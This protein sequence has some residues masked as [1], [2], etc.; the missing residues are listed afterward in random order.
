MIE[1]ILFVDDDANL[2]SSVE[3][4]YRRQFQLE[5]AEGAEAGLA[6]IAE[7][8]PFAVVISDRQM[9]GMDGVQ[10]LSQVRKT[11]PD[12]VRVMLTGNVDLEQAVKAVNEGNIFRFLI[13][14]AP[15]EVLVK[16]LQDAL[17]QYRLITAEK[18]LLNKTLSG[19]IKL[20]TDILSAIE[21]KSVGRT[22]RLRTLITEAAQKLSMADPWEIHLAAMLAPIG[23]VTLPPEITMK[24]RAGQPL[25]KKEEMMLNTVPE[26]AAR[27]LSN[28]PRLQGVSNIVRY[29]DKCYD[30]SGIPTDLVR[31]EAIPAGARLLKILNDMSKLQASNSLTP[32]QALKEMRR[33]EGW[34]DPQ[35]LNAVGTCFGGESVGGD[36][37]KTV[38]RKVT[39]LSVGMVLTSDIYTT[40][41]TLVLT[42]GHQFNDMTLERLQNFEQLVGIKMPIFVE[43]L[44]GS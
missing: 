18:D 4:N 19:C 13:K 23:F 7:R 20:L 33:R 2:L 31:G 41:G 36:A 42:A 30:G 6:K 38:A 16:T 29:Q 27:L 34:Y 8:G 25:S 9:P 14:P 1:K 28:I 17:S 10:F 12:T 44:V 32:P 35:M 11:A 21:L 26:I 40:D 15:P 22:E 39:E 5:T 37:V 24:A 43:S 3:R